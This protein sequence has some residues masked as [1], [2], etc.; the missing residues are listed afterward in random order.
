[1]AQWR[2]FNPTNNP[3]TCIWCGKKLRWPTDFEGHHKYDKAG[4][5]GDGY[6]CGLRCAYQFAVA[7]ADRGRRL[8]RKDV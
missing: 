3:E 7:L 4:D 2:P 5:Y 8:T 6:F 1:M